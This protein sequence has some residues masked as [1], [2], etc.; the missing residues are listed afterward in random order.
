LIIVGKALLRLHHSLILLLI[1][2][3][4]LPPSLIY[5]Y[6][7]GIKKETKSMFK[8]LTLVALQA[9]V[10]LG[11][12]RLI[13]DG[14]VV[15]AI[16]N[17]R[18]ATGNGGMSV[19]G[20]CGGQNTFGT[21][22][23]TTIIQGSEMTVKINYNGG[24]KSAANEFHA[25]YKC[26]ETGPT[27]TEMKAIVDDATLNTQMTL[28]LKDDTTPAPKTDKPNYVD[29]SIGNQVAGTGYSLVFDLPTEALGRC[30]VSLVDQRDWGGCVDLMVTT[31]ASPTLPPSPTPPPTAFM[32][33]EELVGEYKTSPTFDS[34]HSNFPTCCCIESKLSVFEV[35]NGGG[36]RTEFSYEISSEYTYNNS[37]M[38]TPQNAT[39]GSFIKDTE[40]QG[41][42]SASAFMGVDSQLMGF[43]FKR[44]KL[45]IVNKAA[46]TP[47]YCDSTAYLV[48][49][50]VKKVENA[51]TEYAK[52]LAIGKTL[53]AAASAN[54]TVANIQ[55]LTAQA[56][57]VN[58]TYTA[59]KLTVSQLPANETVAKVFAG[60]MTEMN[61]THTNFT[62]MAASATAP[63]GNN[64]DDT[65]P[66]GSSGNGGDA[67]STAGIVI[68]VLLLL[69]VAALLIVYR[70]TVAE[71]LGMGNQ[72]GPV[73]KSVN[74][75][76]DYDINDINNYELPPV[77]VT[78]NG[79]GPPPRAPPR[80][81]Q[82][83]TYNPVEP[84]VDASQSYR[85]VAPSRPVP[86]QRG[87]PPP[88]P[89]SVC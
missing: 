69:L 80:L 71:K 76:N 48:T 11:H 43:E 70:N 1:F 45:E 7:T 83:E 74:N 30:T 66:N 79:R 24:H 68:G 19:A 86:V 75:N 39:G 50:A 65:T 28:T 15:W 46:N 54:A 55:A 36:I 22:G 6:K 16:R 63:G 56:K 62:I 59:L 47:L 60:N 34:C 29:A 67:G 27:Q 40:S 13:N 58:D 23:M 78:S 18:D 44:S 77:V 37:K 64:G 25:V 12:V 88:R 52:Q 87:A 14:P 17:A 51:R 72:G 5:V 57:K 8:L 89:T 20:P 41:K 33:L 73:S 85:D 49:P 26:T 35:A 3:G 81:E 32:T 2:V 10:C 21:N 53:Q 61:M 31:P 42:F 82:N 84:D 38:C 9:A 4:A